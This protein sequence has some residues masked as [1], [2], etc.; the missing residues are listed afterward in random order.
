MKDAAIWAVL[1]VVITAIS[2]ESSEARITDADRAAVPRDVLAAYLEVDSLR[3]YVCP[4]TAFAGADHRMAELRRE[5]RRKYKADFDRF[6]DSDILLRAYCPAPRS[7]AD[8]DGRVKLH[9]A[10][11]DRLADLLG[12]DPLASEGFRS[13]PNGPD[14]DP[15][16]V[17]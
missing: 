15:N 8:F 7:F 12:C 9:R 10:A 14:A 13:C 6:D 1:A 3:L 11:V 17:D 4:S 16:S 5:I 2:F